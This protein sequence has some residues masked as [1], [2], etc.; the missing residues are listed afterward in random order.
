MLGLA[1]G[2]C[3]A[4]LYRRGSRGR[5]GWWGVAAVGVIVLVTMPLDYA[6]ASLVDVS[7]FISEELGLTFIE[8]IVSRDTWSLVPEYWLINN[9]IMTVEFAVAFAFAAVGAFTTV[10]YFFTE[11]KARVLRYEDL[12]YDE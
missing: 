8:A 10:R 7:I 4:L 1:T 3:V 2:V 12:E 5:V 9:A 11:G 6:I